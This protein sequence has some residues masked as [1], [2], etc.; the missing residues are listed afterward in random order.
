M[1][2]TT[3]LTTKSPPPSHRIDRMGS[4][5]ANSESR[6]PPDFTHPDVGV[7]AF[8][9]DRW[10]EQW[11]PRHHLLS[12]LARRF[13]IV[14]VEPPHEW[15]EIPDRIRS[16]FTNRG[17]ETPP[18]LHRH[19]APLWLPRVYRPEAV[20]HRLRQRRVAAAVKRLRRYDVQ[21]CVLYLWRPGFEK[22]LDLVPHDLSVYHIDDE[23]SFSETDVPISETELSVIR[24]SH[25]VFI[26]SPGLMEKKGSINSNTTYVPN[27]VD[28]ELFARETL[29]PQ[30]LREIDHPRIGYTGYLKKQL[31]WHL[32]SHLA[33][34]H[35]DWNLVLIGPKRPHPEIHRH[36]AELSSRENV[37]FLGPKSLEEMSAYPRHLDVCLM[38][39][40]KTAYTDYIFPLKLNEY[41][42][43]G[44]PVVGT[45]IRTLRLFSDVVRL[46]DTPEAWS[47]QVATALSDAEDIQRAERARERRRAVARQ[48]DWNRLAD[49]VASIILRNLGREEEAVAIAPETPRGW[50]AATS[51][52]QAR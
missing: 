9:P 5:A 38:P 46:A 19:R 44:S 17:P 20:A 30:D 25:A 13:P 32:L 1:D 2:R 8:V 12:H 14:W 6:S 7:V 33:S 36:V 31:D 48:H 52:N 29:E 49:L 43:G 50:N 11:Q 26:H 41:L 24:R 22:A 10:S 39:Y 21:K 28:F 35:P 18:G 42:A 34:K 40:R 27:G 51:G 47:R 3:R 16:D 15:R 37:H 4:Q 45:P 23:Y